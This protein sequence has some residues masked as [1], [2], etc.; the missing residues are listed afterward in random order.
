M[1]GYWLIFTWMKRYWLIFT[2]MKGDWLIFTWMKGDGLIFNRNEKEKTDF[3]HEWKDMDWFL[4][5]WKEMDWFFTWMEENRLIFEIS[6]CGS[7]LSIISSYSDSYKYLNHTVNTVFKQKEDTPPHFK[8]KC[9]Y[10]MSQKTVVIIRTSILKPI[11]TFWTWL[12]FT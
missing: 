9:L 10:R 12:I 6:N 2:W 11:L 3:L 5:E 7:W 4:P 8:N 1:K